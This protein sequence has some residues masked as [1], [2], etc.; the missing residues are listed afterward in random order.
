VGRLLKE[1]RMDD[2]EDWDDDEEEYD[3]NDPQREPVYGS[4]AQAFKTF[5]GNFAYRD[6]MTKYCTKEDCRSGHKTMNISKPGSATVVD[7]Y[8]RWERVVEKF[9]FKRV[10][11][12]DTFRTNRALEEF[13]RQVMTHPT[14]TGQ[15][16]RVWFWGQ[17]RPYQ[18]LVAR[19]HF[20]N[21]GKAVYVSIP[22]QMATIDV[23]LHELPTSSPAPPQGTPMAPP[24]ATTC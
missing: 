18:G 5:G 7:G 4:E 24:S 20:N 9:H 16:D 17:R 1:T 8:P 19:T 13:A 12:E 3:P 15:T 6:T 14:W 10:W 11:R 23:V 2:Y 22:Y 21:E